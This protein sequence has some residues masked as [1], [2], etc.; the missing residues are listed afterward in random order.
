MFTSRVA[1]AGLH[2][3]SPKHGPIE[4]VLFDL[5]DTLIDRAAGFRRFCVDL[6]RSSTA[7]QR[8]S[9]EDQAVERIIE[10]DR[11]G[12]SDR[13]EMFAEVLSVWPGTFRDTDHAVEFYLE[14]YLRL[15]PL[16]PET[17]RLLGDLRSRGI[18]FGIVTNGGSEMQWAKV[19][20]SGAGGFTDAV[21]VSEDVG[22]RKPDPRIFEVALSKID[23]KADTTLFVGDNPEADIAGA[24][25]VGMQ[26]AWMRLGRQWPLDSLRPDY[27]LDH[28][29]EVRGI[30]LG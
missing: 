10:L 30:V 22:F 13:H 23:S 4:A 9:T 6:Y 8:V 2:P 24:S 25:G 11:S 16:A 5:D 26:T 7:M 1:G 21:V 29:S 18:P 28:V 14:T 17:K 15:L 27:V 20:A 12:M 19:R 3:V